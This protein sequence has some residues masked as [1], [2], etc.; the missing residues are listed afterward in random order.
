MHGIA[1]LLATS[2]LCFTTGTVGLKRIFKNLRLTQSEAIFR[3]VK[4]RQE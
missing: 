1:G 2:M 4:K 3:F